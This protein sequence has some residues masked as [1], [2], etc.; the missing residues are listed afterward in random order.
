VADFVNYNSRDVE[1]PPGCKNL[2]DVLK[3]APTESPRYP[4]LPSGAQPEQMQ[5]GKID[6]LEDDMTWLISESIKPSFLAILVPG[7]PLE[8]RCETDA[9]P[10]HLYLA[11]PSGEL[12]R[13]ERVRAFFGA[14]DWNPLQDST[15][16]DGCRFMRYMRF[17]LPCVVGPVS[18]LVGALLREVY[19]VRDTTPLRFVYG[20]QP[21]GEW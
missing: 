5:V 4:K 16:L 9:G 14:H 1:L 19:D 6:E 2:I 8:L 7:F 20:R 12:R 11:V 18:D 13:A 3:Q 15:E 21:G 17:N 10:L